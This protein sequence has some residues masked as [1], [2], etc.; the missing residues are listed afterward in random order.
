MSI[1]ILVTIV[2]L[3]CIIVALMAYNVSIHKKISKFS[4]ISEKING[5]NVLQNFMDTIGEYS[6]VE[7]KIQKLKS[8]KRDLVDSV[9]SVDRNIVKSLTIDDIRE[10]FSAD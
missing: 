4:N 7:E 6:S 5:L 10:I 3:V 8:R 9:I 2:V 1:A